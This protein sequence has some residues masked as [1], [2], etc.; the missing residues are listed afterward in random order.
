MCPLRS[1]QIYA[2]KGIVPG[3][4]Q[5][6]DGGAWTFDR[7]QLRRW[8]RERE[9]QA[10][11]MPPMMPKGLPM[12]GGTGSRFAAKSIDEACRRAIGLKPKKR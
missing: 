2:A 3:A 4:R 8:L 5:L 9:Q 11:R 12:S 6:V 7:T 1:M 10:N